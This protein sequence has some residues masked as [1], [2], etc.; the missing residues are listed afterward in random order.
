[1]AVGLTLRWEAGSITMAA[2]AAK[3]GAPAAVASV[4]QERRDI[5]AYSVVRQ[6]RIERAIRWPEGA[7]A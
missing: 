7:A 1:M 6:V 3:S 4:V 5:A 2:T